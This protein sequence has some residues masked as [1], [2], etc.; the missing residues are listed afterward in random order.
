MRIAIVNFFA[1][2]AQTVVGFGAPLI[3]MPFMI[4]WLGPKTAT[5]LSTLVGLL[6]SIAV[7]LYYRSHFNFKAVFKLLVTAIIGVPI[8]V[9]LLNIIDS[10]ALQ[11]FLGAIVLGYALYSIAGPKL[12]ELKSQYWDYIFGFIA[13]VMGGALNTSGPII[14]IYASFKQ[15][16]SEEFRS[17]LQGFFMVTN[18]AILFSHYA[19]GNLDQQFTATLLP[20]L[21]GMAIAIVV[22]LIISSRINEGFFRKL[23]LAVLIVSGIQL[24]R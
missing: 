20:A 3:S 9:Y 16:D 6:T 24:L 7:I 2:L 14:V 15:W 1:T 19:N 5:P 22:G 13:G 12:P 11:I 18:V 8:G 23:V 17:N 10:S 21:G 4:V